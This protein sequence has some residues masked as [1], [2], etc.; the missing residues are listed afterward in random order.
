MSV[1]PVFSQVRS[2]QPPNRAEKNLEGDGFQ[3]PEGNPTFSIL[4][5]NTL[6]SWLQV[7][8]H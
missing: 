2:L 8:L 7:T 6:L 1:R 4:S 3:R 5:Q